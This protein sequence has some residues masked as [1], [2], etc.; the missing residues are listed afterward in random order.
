[1]WVPHVVLV[2]RGVPST[3]SECNDSHHI[4]EAPSHVQGKI[5]CCAENEPKAE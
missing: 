3:P 5:N 2:E 4:L 1:M